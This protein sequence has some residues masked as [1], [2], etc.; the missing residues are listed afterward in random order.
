MPGF[1]KMGA[2]HTVDSTDKEDESNS[3][4]QCQMDDNM[5]G[6]Y[7]LSDLLVLFCYLPITGHYYIFFFSFRYLYL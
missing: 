1:D 7:L 5:E 3:Q 2:Y 6:I 4:S